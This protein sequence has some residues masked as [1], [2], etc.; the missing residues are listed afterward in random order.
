MNEEY[1]AVLFEVM[2]SSG[3]DPRTV[4]ANAYIQQMSANADN[5]SGRR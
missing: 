3:I 5:V 1:A 2:V 4:S